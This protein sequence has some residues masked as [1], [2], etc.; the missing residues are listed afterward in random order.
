MYNLY[1]FFWDGGRAG[2]IESLFFATPEQIDNLIGKTIYLGD[3]LGKHSDVS[4]TVEVGDIKKIELSKKTL[5]EMHIILTDSVCGYNPLTYLDDDDDEIYF[6]YFCG[7]SVSLSDLEYD[8]D[9]NEC[10]SDC[11]AEYDKENS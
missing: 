7:E 1:R 6:C 11:L 5:E 9:G 2:Q 3:V 4:G 8:E 10:H